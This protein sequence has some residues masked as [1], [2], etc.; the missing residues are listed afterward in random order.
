M[1][2]RHSRCSVLVVLLCALSAAAFAQQ[3]T[4]TISGTITDST[5]AVV[6]RAVVVVTNVQTGIT[7]RTTATES[8]SYLVP[9]LRPGD[10]SVAVESKGFQ[11]T[12]RTG[13]TLQVAQVGAHRRHAAD[14]RRSPKPSKSSPRRRCSTR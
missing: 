2:R 6:P 9:S 8:G 4:A 13:V 1:V 14:R 10:Y 3:E 5:G 11:K 12:V 7:V